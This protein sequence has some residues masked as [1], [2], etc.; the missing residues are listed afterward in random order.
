MSLQI[1]LIGL[2]NVGKTTLFNALTGG[3]APVAPYPFTT[4]ERNVGVVMVPDERLQRIAALVNPEEIVPTTIEFVD[5]AGLVKGASEGEGLGNQFLGHIRDVDAVC[6]VVRCFSAADIPHVTPELNPKDDIE[7][8]ELELALA[9]LA[10]VARR[11][12]KLRRQVKGGKGEYEE[13]LELLERLH[14]VLS[15]GRQVRKLLLNAEEKEIL[16]PLNLL[17]NKPRLYVANVDEEALPSGSELAAAAKESANAEVIVLCAELEAELLEWPQEE[18][19]AYREEV[20]LEEPGLNRLIE[21]S[22]R[23]LDLVTFF[24]T[25]GGREV[26]AW[27]VPGGTPAVEAAG[28]IH[29]DMKKGFIRAEII[30]YED[31]MRAGSFARARERGLLRLEGRDYWIREGDI[32]HIRFHL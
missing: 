10:T 28:K 9:D 11:L 31:L 32:V 13:E 3:H 30:S 17:T 12:E 16:R 15:Q 25:T 8:V 23:L 1:G 22:Y 4:L 29:T 5:I 2:P 26:R 7:V 20:G 14:Q 24:T 18:A 19:Q 21:A 6:M 27:T